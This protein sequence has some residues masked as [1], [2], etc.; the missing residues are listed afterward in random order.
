M[1]RVDRTDERPIKKWRPIIET[2]TG[3]K[4]SYIV[5]LICLY[6]EWYTS[7]LEDQNTI[8]DRIFEINSKIDG[9]QR[10]EVIGQ[11]FN[12]ANC[13]IEYKLSNGSFIPIEKKY[14]FGYKI[15]DEDI[16][17]LFGEE[18]IK[19]LDK[20]EYYITDP[21]KFRDKKIDKVLL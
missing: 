12:P 13:E 2:K 17:D 6:C 11:Y 7:D 9:Y 15:P 19:D 21:Q 16:L 10:I 18:F 5:E 4:N 8:I 14:N 3:I 1:R 20:W